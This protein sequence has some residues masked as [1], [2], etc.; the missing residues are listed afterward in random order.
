MFRHVDDVPKIRKRFK[1]KGVYVSAYRYVDAEH[2]SDESL[3][4][5]DMYIDLDKNDLVDEEK[6]EEAFEAIREDALKTLGF[7][8]AILHVDMDMIRIYFSGMKGLHIIVP[9]QV[10]GITPMKELNH[11]FGLI[12]KEINNMTKHKTVDTGIY[13]NARLFSIHGGIH[14]E[15]D[16]YK[17]ALTIDELRSLSF[18]QIQR[19][20]LK[21]KDVNYRPARYN[22]K[23]NRVFKSYIESWEKEKQALKKKS[24]KGGDKTLDFC[25]P[26]IKS[27]LTQPCLPGS[28]NNTAAALSSYFF[29]RGYSKDKG[30]R[31]LIR[32]NDRFANLSESE[33]STTFES[34]Y[35]REYTYGC[36]TFEQ[37]GTCVLGECKIGKNRQG[38]KK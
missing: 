8:N 16:C 21:P 20:S 38:A 15:T 7:F 36:S 27:I 35:R 6:A 22:T 31:K 4:I 11:I 3:L 2:R 9:Y 12:A 24:G 34:I 37:V 14:P 10:L 18:K 5:G 33:L 1:N 25:P 30:W 19:L 23:S 17:I 13:D 29:Q 26:C 32:W 28:R